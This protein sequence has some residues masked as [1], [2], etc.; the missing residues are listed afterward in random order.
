MKFSSREDIEAPIDAVFVMVSDFALFEHVATRR[1]ARV[2][3]TDTLAEPGVGMTWDAAF[4][5]RGKRRELAL[6]VTDHQPPAGF[7]VEGVSQGMTGIFAVQLEALSPDRTRLAVQLDVKPRNLPARLL[8]QSLRL[9]KTSLTK[10]FKLRVAEYAR[11]L[12]ER[13]RLDT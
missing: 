9:A 2:R 5:M 1:G 11:E 10:R 3:R 8:I 6:A 4:P 7:S 12:E 13:Y